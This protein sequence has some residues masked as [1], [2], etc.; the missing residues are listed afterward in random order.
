[1]TDNPLE[2]EWRKHHWRGVSVY[3][4]AR[5]EHAWLMRLDS[6]VYSKIASRLGCS[7]SR[8]PQIIE[9]RIRNLNKAREAA[10]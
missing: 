2:D 1:V 7:K 9:K 10:E 3:N 5:Y 4:E 6:K 8:I